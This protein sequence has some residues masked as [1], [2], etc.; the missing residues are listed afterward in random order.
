ME[1]EEVD[2]EWELTYQSGHMVAPEDKSRH[3]QMIEQ[4][5][6]NYNNCSAL[7]NHCMRM[8]GLCKLMI[9]SSVLTLSE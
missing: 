3:K 2:E 1:D 6:E 5:K 9:Q 7:S 4:A 8:K